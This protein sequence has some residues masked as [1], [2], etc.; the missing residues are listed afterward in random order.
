MARSNPGILTGRRQES[1][2]DRGFDGSRGWSDVTTSQ[3]MQV[4]R[5]WKEQGTDSPLESRK[6][7]VVRQPDFI[8]YGLLLD[9][10]PQRLENRFVLLEATKCVVV[11]CNQGEQHRAQERLRQTVVPGAQGE[12]ESG[13]RQRNQAWRRHLGTHHT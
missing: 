2:G 6:D 8:P 13:Q 12:C 10:G 5:S 1:L 11:C 9:L 3:G 7:P 4:P